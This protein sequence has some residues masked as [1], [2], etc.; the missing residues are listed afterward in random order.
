MGDASKERLLEEYQRKY[1]LEEMPTAR[2]THPQATATSAV[3]TH[4]QPAPIE[5]FVERARRLFNER[6]TIAASIDNTTM[7]VAVRPAVRESPPQPNAFIDAALYIKLKTTLEVIFVSGWGEFILQ[8]QFNE[9]DDRMSKLEKAKTSP[10]P[11]RKQP[12]S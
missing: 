12:W 9:L 3:P 5:T 2:V 4:A 1:E 11:R 7:A 8:Y 10:R 6:D